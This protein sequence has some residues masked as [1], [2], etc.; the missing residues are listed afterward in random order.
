ML[1]PYARVLAHP[2][3][4]AFFLT[5]LVAR[6]PM[7]MIG[8]GIVLLVEGVRGSYGIAGLVTGAFVFSEGALAL[9]QGRLLDR[10]G[11]AAV[12]VPAAVVSN[13]SLVA[14]TVAVLEEAPIPLLLLLAALGGATFPQVGSAVRARWSWLLAGQTASKDTAFALEG[15]ADEVAFVAGP[16]L[17]TVLATTIHPTVGLLTA[18]VVALVGTLAFARLTVTQP[19]S[20]RSEGDTGPATP[21]VWRTLGP[22]TAV[23][24]G[25]GTLFG[26]MEV[27][28]VA[29]AQEQGNQSAAGLL[30]ALWAAASLVAGV[31]TGL[32]TWRV[33]AATRMRRSTAA[34]AIVVLPLPFVPSLALMAALLLVIGLAVA[35]SLIAMVSAVEAG[36]P[37]GR[38]TESLAVAHTGL[39]VGVALGAATA[40][41]VVDRVGPSGAYAVPIAA[42]A[43]AALAAQA[44]RGP[45]GAGA[46]READVSRRV[47]TPDTDVPAQ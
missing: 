28:T 45:R 13:L 37:A 44:S 26:G 23:A 12:L 6:A 42:I 43:L 11:Q 46:P 25:L 4:R 35:P 1:S 32:V 7:A 38:L 39:A 17:V 30:L 2:G 33:D 20:G 10:F 9:V 5:G 14:L 40:G 22:A 24:V 19:P 16:V 21:L 18:A 29:F 47:A 3:A 31:V 34:F 41:A 27:V 36:A 15:V 8:L